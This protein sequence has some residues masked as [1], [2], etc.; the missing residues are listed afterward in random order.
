MSS[1]QETVCD[2]AG[3]KTSHCPHWRDAS[4]THNIHHYNWEILRNKDLDGGWWWKALSTK[5]AKL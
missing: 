1:N 5:P 4:C 2:G 3:T